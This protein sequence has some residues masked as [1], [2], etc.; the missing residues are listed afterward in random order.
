MD[1][2]SVIVPVYNIEDCVEECIQSILKQDWQNMQIL[3]IDDGSKDKSGAICDKYAG[4]DQRIEVVHQDN[5]G[6]SAALNTGLD[7]ANGDWILF[8]DG[9]DVICSNLI[10]SCMKKIK[11]EETDIVQYAFRS[12]SNPEGLKK[13]LEIS[14]EV[15]KADRVITGEEG[16]SYICLNENP[17]DYPNLRLTTTIRWSKLYRSN[18]FENIRYPEGKIHED[19]WSVHYVFSK[20]RKMVFSPFVGY[21]Y[22]IR[23][24]SI[25]QT[26]VSVKSMDKADAFLDRVHFFKE[27]K[28]YEYKKYMVNKCLIYCMQIFCRGEHSDKQEQAMIREKVNAILKQLSSEKKDFS[29]KSRVY[30]LNYKL[31]PVL[32]RK[33]FLWHHK[34]K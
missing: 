8:V 14:E 18:L 12:F 23:E 10:S 19:E 31:C 15:S 5:G 34:R 22:R 25:M 4:T 33:I 7:H 17:S 20:A 1:K 11:D 2:V 24:K 16:F 30:Y 26:G 28:Y 6:L 29:L 21:C 9:D 27:N 3:L 32:L 13:I